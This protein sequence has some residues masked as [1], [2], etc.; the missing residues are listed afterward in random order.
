MRPT[1]EIHVRIAESLGVYEI[2]FGEV[3]DCKQNRARKG[4][5]FLFLARPTRLIEPV[6]PAFGVRHFVRK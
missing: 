6:T 3:P 2:R 1:R 5:R 4:A